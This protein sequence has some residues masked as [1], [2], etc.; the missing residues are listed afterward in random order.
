[1]KKP[2]KAPKSSKLLFKN[3]HSAAK[4]IAA[5]KIYALWIDVL[6]RPIKKLTDPPSN[7][8]IPNVI[9]YADFLNHTPQFSSYHLNLQQADVVNVQTM[10]DL[11]GAI[12]ANFQSNGWTV[13]AN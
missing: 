7:Y 5:S 6:G 11:G 13:T 3:A 12:V 2:N 4:S 8:N 10:G 9:A 1:L